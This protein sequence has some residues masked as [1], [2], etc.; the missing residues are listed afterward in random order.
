M[1]S[2]LRSVRGLAVLPAR[3]LR[4]VRRVVTPQF[5]QERGVG[6]K[7]AVEGLDGVLVRFDCLA[8]PVFAEAN[9]GFFSVSARM[10]SLIS[11]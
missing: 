9:P 5:I 3:L 7:G 8:N 6:L 11:A 10:G 4:E 1:P 2:L